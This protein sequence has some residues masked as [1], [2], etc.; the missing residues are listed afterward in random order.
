MHSGQTVLIAI[1]LNSFITFLS[2]IAPASA[3]ITG[4]T[5]AA[6]ACYGLL[7]IIFLITIAAALL[8]HKRRKRERKYFTVEVKRDILRKQGH[9]CANCNWNTGVFDFDHKDGNRSNNKM[10]NCLALCP[11]CH[12]KKS[13]GLIEIKKKSRGSIKLIVFLFL[14]LLLVAFIFSNGPN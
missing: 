2:F 12:A 5:S 8:I 9:K 14:F 13:R 1:M 11:N 7:F 4:N 3:Q 10:S 6:A